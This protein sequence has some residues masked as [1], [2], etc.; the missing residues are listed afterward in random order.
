MTYVAN[1]PDESKMALLDVTKFECTW[2]LAYEL[3][4]QI[5]LPAGTRREVITL[6]NNS[7]GSRFNP[8][9]QVFQGPTR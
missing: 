6:F 4:K 5:V 7:F 3:I 8:D 2:R 9:L 1:L